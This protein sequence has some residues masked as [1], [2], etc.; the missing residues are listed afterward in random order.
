M[1]SMNFITALI[2]LTKKSNTTKKSNIVLCRT[3][4]KPLTNDVKSILKMEMG[5]NIKNICCYYI[6]P[7]IPSHTQDKLAVLPL[8]HLF[9][10]R[11]DGNIREIPLKKIT[12][13]FLS[14][15]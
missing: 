8:L 5:L 10:K 1:H 2:S 13:S 11:N 9:M 12:R 6:I 14:I 15:S 4:M 3:A 7:I